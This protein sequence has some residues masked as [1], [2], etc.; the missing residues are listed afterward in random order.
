MTVVQ[1]SSLTAVDLQFCRNLT[2]TLITE[3]G[4]CNPSASSFALP[5]YNSIQG[6]SGATLPVSVMRRKS[7]GALSNYPIWFLGAT[8]YIY[9]YI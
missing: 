9:I 2:E 6:K 3:K 7:G 1:G 4:L 5:G 8:K